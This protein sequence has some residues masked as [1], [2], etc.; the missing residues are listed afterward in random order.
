[1]SKNK[2]FIIEH[3]ENELGHWC[4]M[5]YKHIS[6]TVGKDNLWFTNLKNIKNKK[7]LIKFGKLCDESIKE[8]NLKNACVLDPESEITL[9]PSNSKEI[10]YFIFGGILGDYP[11]RARTKSELTKFI[12]KSKVYNIGKEQMSTDNAVLVVK[13]IIEGQNLKDL[14]FQD[15]IEI[16]LNKVESIQLPYRYRLING[17]IFMSEELIKYLKNK[18]EF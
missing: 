2:I 11:P 9:T 17:K 7:D 14:K 15:E 6:K 18:K 13:E 16:P 5:E 1:M 10:E 8:L 4:I 12:K 3:L